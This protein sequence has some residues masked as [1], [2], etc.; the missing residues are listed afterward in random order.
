MHLQED[1][2][3]GLTSAPPRGSPIVERFPSPYSSLAAE[4]YQ[5]A[6]YRLSS[7]PV[8]PTSLL[9]SRAALP[10]ATRVLWYIILVTA[11]QSLV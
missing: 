1:D 8:K 2:G 7:V 5:N 4:W 9:Q 11:G 10:S 3:F 6:G